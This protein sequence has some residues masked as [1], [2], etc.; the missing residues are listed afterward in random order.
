MTD[1]EV[2][3][4]IQSAVQ[5]F[6]SNDLT[7]N[8]IR[9]FQTLG[10]NT[11]RQN[12]FPEKTFEFFKDSFLEGNQNFKEDKAQVKEWKS[13]DL[14][15]QLTRDELSGQ[16]SLFSNGRVK[17]EGEDK[18]TV[19]ETY[20]FFALELT[21]PDYTRTALAQITR[22]INKVFPMPVMILFKH[23]AISPCR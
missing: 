16:K 11:D 19:M 23:G 1:T 8:A 3:R 21:K 5:S 14:L 15:F 13:A 20:L 9:F 22:E 17:W 4:L 6:A 2:K 7:G 18:E 12:P 10:Y